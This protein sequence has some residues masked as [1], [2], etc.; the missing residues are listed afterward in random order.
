MSYFD[1]GAGTPVLLVH[2][3]SASKKLWRFVVPSLAGRARCLV[4][5]LPGHGDSDKPERLS[6][7]GF[8]QLLDEFLTT[9]GVPRV[10]AV[11]HSMGGMI[12]TR[13]ALARPERVGRLVLCNAPVHGPSSL[14]IS[15]R[16]MV[17]PY[18]RALFF[19]FY[20]SPRMRR[21]L[22]RDF[23]VAQDADPE[24]AIDLMR[25]TYRGLTSAVD[26]LRATDLTPELSR[27]A[28]PVLA[29]TSTGDD[30][31]DPAQADLLR[32]ALPNVRCHVFDCGHL[33]MLERREAFV[34]L[35]QEFL[36]ES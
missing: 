21:F 23:G 6:I 20:R 30:V 36:F 1:E 13:L 17:A 11:G 31:I 3:W 2:G 19:M 9:L 32:R 10:S 25:G 7:E 14:R 4:P 5:D 26:S 18:L 33:P 24:L 34:R 22:S 28:I 8:V 35:L 12:V 27:L 16:I 29:I 15:K